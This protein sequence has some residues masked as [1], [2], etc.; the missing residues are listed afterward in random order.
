MESLKT[1]QELAASLAFS[2]GLPFLFNSHR[3]LDGY[4]K[5]DDR[6]SHLFE[7]EN[8]TETND[9]VPIEL[10]WHQLCGVHS[11]IRKNFSSSEESQRLCPGILIADDVG[12]GKTFQ[13]AALIAFLCDLVIRQNLAN[14]NSPPIIRAYFFTHKPC[15]H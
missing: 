2:Q 8:T 13:A 12:L 3:H 11:I 4:T 1:P 14:P 7:D 5:W 10:H 9:I 6:Y 15:R